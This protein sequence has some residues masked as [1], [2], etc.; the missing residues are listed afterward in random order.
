MWLSKIKRVNCDSEEINVG[1]STNIGDHCQY[2]IRTKQLDEMKKWL[3]PL[4][5]DETPKWLAE[6]VPIEKKE[7]NIATRF[8]FN[9]ISNT[10]MPSKNESI[11]HLAQAACLGCVIEETQINLRT[12]VASEILMRARQSQTSLPFQV[13]ITELCKQAQV[14]RDTKSDVEVMPT[15]STD[16]W[17]IEDN[18]VSSNGPEREDAEGKHETAMK[19]KKGESPSHSAASTNF[20]E[21][22]A[23]AIF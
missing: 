17:K 1:M 21:R 22:S 9:F 2:L 10:V 19:R 6:G 5:A 7:L 12:I 18:T 13:L 3:A 4:I 8:W 20:T 23:S 11:F 15:T 14:P 16:I